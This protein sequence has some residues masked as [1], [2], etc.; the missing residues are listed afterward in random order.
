MDQVDLL[1]MCRVRGVSW[2]FL[3]REAQLLVGYPDSPLVGEDAGDG[4]L[5]GAAPA[6]GH[7]APDATGLHQD[8]VSY[9]IR[10]HELLR[11]G[12]HTLLLWAGDVHAA[13]S[14]RRLGD[15]VSGQLRGR[16][17][18]HLVVGAPVARAETA[19]PR[20]GSLSRPSIWSRQNGLR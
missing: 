19:G 7:R 4:G 3:A 13:E 10:L 14:Q 20:Q 15:Q 9:P 1:V 17:H 12:G 16:V 18:C 2:N 8:A 5:D 11:H 6:A